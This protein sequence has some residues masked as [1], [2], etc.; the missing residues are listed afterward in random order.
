MVWQWIGSTIFATMALLS[1]AMTFGTFDALAYIACVLMLAA[2][3]LLFPPLW[4]GKPNALPRI[5]V[6]LVLATGGL[7]TPFQHSVKIDLPRPAHR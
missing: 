3:A 6:A 7:F 4:R 5:I 1:L 2:A